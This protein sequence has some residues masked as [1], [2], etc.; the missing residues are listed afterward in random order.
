MIYSI[1]IFTSFFSNKPQHHNLY[2]NFIHTWAAIPCSTSRIC[3]SWTRPR[4]RLSPFPAHSYL[5]STLLVLTHPAACYLSPMIHISHV[6]PPLT[7]RRIKTFIQVNI[8]SAWYLLYNG[9]IYTIQHFFLHFSSLLGRLAG[10][11]LSC[12]EH[13]KSYAT[14]RRRRIALAVLKS[15]LFIQKLLELNC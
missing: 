6:R 15:F 10:P 3:P 13:W 8:M 14:N 11:K 9:H 4:V 7:T 12:R 5:L 2:I 1:L